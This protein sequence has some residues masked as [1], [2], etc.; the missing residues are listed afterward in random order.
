VDNKT[1]TIKINGVELT[2]DGD[3]TILEACRKTG[4]EIPTLCYMKDVCEEGSCGVC[5]VEVAKAR[6]LQRACITEVF[7]G[8]EIKTNTQKVRLAR[9]LS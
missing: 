2:V 7:D 9:C 3:S 5:V 1:V 4:I 6:T 8:M